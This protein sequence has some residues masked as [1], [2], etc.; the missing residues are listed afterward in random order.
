MDAAILISGLV[1]I[2]VALIGLV[3]VQWRRSGRVVPNPSD[4]ENTQVAALSAAFLIGQ[5]DRLYDKLDGI[6][7]LLR[8]R[9]P[10]RG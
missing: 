6:E 10:P 9:L 1:A 8:D 3:G 5:F 4:P 7:G 2:I